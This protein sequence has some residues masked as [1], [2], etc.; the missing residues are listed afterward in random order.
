MSQIDYVNKL[1][2]EFGYFDSAKFWGMWNGFNVYI[3]KD[4]GDFI[5]LADG[6]YVRT[7]AED[8]YSQILKNGVCML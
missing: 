3:P 2:R 6:E 8:E 4:D 7:C 5:V 1:L